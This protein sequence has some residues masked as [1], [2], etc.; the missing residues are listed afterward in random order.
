[1]VFFLV[2]LIGLGLPLLFLKLK[3]NLAKWWPSILLL[4]A[5]LL[6]GLKIVFFPAQ[7]MAVLGEIV[8]LLLIGCGL[9]SSLTCAIILH[10]LKK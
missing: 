6:L 2:F 7:E 4:L 3:A 10:Y 5:A 1:M 9:A 8:T